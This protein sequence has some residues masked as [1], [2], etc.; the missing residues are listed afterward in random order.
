MR[1]LGAKHRRES[2]VKTLLEFF[3]AVGTMLGFFVGGWALLDVFA[4]RKKA[5]PD[6]TIRYEWTPGGH[7]YT[8]Y[9]G[10]P[11]NARDYPRRISQSVDYETALDTLRCYREV[12]GIPHV[13]LPRWREPN[14]DDP[15]NRRF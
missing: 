12:N 4:N 10:D 6:G 3:L 13:V 8:V 1:R 15:V 9:A 7:M 11:G 2:A 5:A 14:Y